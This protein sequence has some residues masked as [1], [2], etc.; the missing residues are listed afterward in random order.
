MSNERIPQQK[1]PTSYNQYLLENTTF[2]DDAV[3]IF[4]TLSGCARIILDKLHHSWTG[5]LLTQDGIQS[6][7]RYHGN[8]P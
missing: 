5:R 1:Q 4:D 2:Y 3:L 6:P 7:G 8:T